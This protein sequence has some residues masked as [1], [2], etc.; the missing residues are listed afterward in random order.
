[1]GCSSD[2]RNR[3]AGRGG[4]PRGPLCFFPLLFPH[5]SPPGSAAWIVAPRLDTDRGTASA[6]L[7]SALAGRPP[8]PGSLRRAGREPYHEE[9]SLSGRAL[10]G[11]I[12]PHPPRQL[13]ADGQAEPHA[14]L[15]L[16][17]APVQLDEGVEDRLQL[18]RG[19]PRAV[20]LDA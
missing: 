14:F 9:A 4:Q 20:V 8:S 13:A 2:R 1:A 12:T 17:Q 10:D 7:L 11:E 6:P 5:H 16:V 3:R 18:L 15:G 19:D